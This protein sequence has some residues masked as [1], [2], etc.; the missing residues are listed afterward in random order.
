MIK[1]IILDDNGKDQCI[2]GTDFL[3]HPDIHEIINFKENYI[4]IQ[5]V[6]LPLK[7]IASVCSQTELFLTAANDK[8]L[9]E[10]PEEERVSFYDDKSD[11]SAKLKK[12]RPNN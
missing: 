1:F 6:K 11:I 5:D 8:V 9:E 12:W 10:I 2:I 3:A 7:V 4:K